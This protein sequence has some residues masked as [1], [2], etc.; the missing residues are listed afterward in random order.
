[1][2]HK[3]LF[4]FLALLL[5]LMS[6]VSAYA[7]GMEGFGF[8]LVLFIAFVSTIPGAIIKNVLSHYMK[9]REDF[10]NIVPL[11][12]VAESIIMVI[13]SLLGSA[14]VAGFESS[15]YRPIFLYPAI[16]IHIMLATFPNLF[17]LKEGKQKFSK[18]FSKFE[19]II[20]AVMFS[21]FTPAVFAALI[22]IVAY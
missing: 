15:H 2:R 13:S 19:N 5:C 8:L 1:M 17:L 11:V 10:K 20:N 4:I 21:I 7:S 6:P 3:Y 16:P 18:I 12:M 9:K 22:S 14:L